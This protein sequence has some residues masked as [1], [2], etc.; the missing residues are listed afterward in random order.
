MSVMPQKAKYDL[1]GLDFGGET[2]GQRLARL[3]KQEGYTQVELAEKTGLQQSLLSAYERG[4]LRLSAEVAALLIKALGISA[5]DLFAV[6][7]SRKTRRGPT[8]KL[9]RL[10]EKAS[11]L[12][13]RQQEKVIE[14]VS[15]F[16]DKQK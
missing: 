7:G 14:F 16:V 10:F 9:Q 1:S 3:R 5:D 13:R 15:A 12:P 11:K 4:R 2:L 6:N 8:G